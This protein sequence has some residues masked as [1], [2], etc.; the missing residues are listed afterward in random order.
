MSR[1]GH[2]PFPWKAVEVCDDDGNLTGVDIGN[3]K[4]DVCAA[5]VAAGRADGNMDERVMTNEDRA[6][7][8]L[9]LAIPKMLRLLRGFANAR[10]MGQMARLA[11]AS[12]VLLQK[13]PKPNKS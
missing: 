11:A 12:D 2:T 3:V 13:L 9:I 10:T 5:H 7:I 6:N 8:K 4:L 1:S